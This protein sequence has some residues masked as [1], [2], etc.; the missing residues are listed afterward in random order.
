MRF[1]DELVVVKV[2][3]LLLDGEVGQG[4]D[5]A[6]EQHLALPHLEHEARLQPPGQQ[7]VTY[8]GPALD[9]RRLLLTLKYRDLQS[10][11]SSSVHC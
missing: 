2:E 7:E 5:L 10:D 4:D 3:D 8:Q 11:L 9:R 1:E 6:E